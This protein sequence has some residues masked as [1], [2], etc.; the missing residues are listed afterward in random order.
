M[1]ENEIRNRIFWQ[2][3]RGMQELDLI[4]VPFLQ[5]G[6]YDELS[7][8]DKKLYVTLLREEDQTLFDWFLGKGAP[9]HPDALHILNIVRAWH[10]RTAKK[11]DA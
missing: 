9:E 2:S 8:T 7:D 4:L 5:E 1:N 11:Y 3:R 6:G 10:G